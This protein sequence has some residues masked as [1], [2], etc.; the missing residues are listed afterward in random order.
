MLSSGNGKI[1]ITIVQYTY[2]NLIQNYEDL[3]YIQYKN[4]NI[5][6]VGPKTNGIGYISKHDTDFLQKQISALAAVVYQ[7]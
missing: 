5:C 4:I 7:I 1:W 6:N 3:V 2:L